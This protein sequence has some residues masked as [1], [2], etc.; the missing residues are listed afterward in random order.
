MA[1]RQKRQCGTGSIVHEKH[2]LAI[3]WPEYYL[4]ETGERKRKMRYAFLGDVSER[5]ASSQL[6]DRVVQARRDPPKPIT[7]P[8]MFS[9]HVARWKRDI[10]NSAGTDTVDL[11]KYSV[12]IVRSD[13]IRSR[14]LPTFG[15]FALAEV[16]TTSI[17]EWVTGLRKDGLKASTIRNYY[18]TLKV[19][20]A[21][22]VVW[23]ELKENPAWG[24]DLP[25]IRK[26]EQDEKKWALTPEEAGQ[27]LRKI[28]ALKPRTMVALAITAGLRR[29]ELI[30]AR[31]KS[32]DEV[33]SG[34][35]VVE[36]SYQGHIGTPKTEAGERTVPLDQWTMDLLSKWRGL[37]KHTRP[38]D[39]IFATRTGKQE[40][41]QNILRRYVW[42]ACEALKLRRPSWNTF[43]RTFSTWLDQHAI[44]GKTIAA[45]MGH[46]K[47]DTSQNFYIQTNDEAK[48]VAAGKIGEELSRNFVQDDQTGVPWLN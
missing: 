20:L 42:P 44:R 13:I 39:F 3:R 41:P 40:N 25:K 4:L 1:Q 32:L 2:G 31:W 16:S 34:I 12:R 45:M 30:A 6:L 29:G 26:K 11:Y 22:A 27:L 23:K 28:Q 48:R 18:K 35:A 21:K 5:E 9:E 46:S 19:I 33:S 14:I 17:Q 38:D 24:V 10:L 36:A 47:P 43:R 7:A 8:V 15:K 37:S